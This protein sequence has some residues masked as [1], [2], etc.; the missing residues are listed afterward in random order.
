[1]KGARLAARGKEGKKA[2]RPVG[3]WK[4]GKEEGLRIARLRR[5]LK[6]GSRSV[7]DKR[8]V[9]EHGGYGKGGGGA[10]ADDGKR[11][12]GFSLAQARVVVQEGPFW[13]NVCLVTFFFGA[14]RAPLQI[15][16]VFYVC[17]GL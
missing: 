1:M 10:G 11:V 16:I 8:S 9:A 15:S 2:R 12:E 5:G 6:L 17:L 4:E 13:D 3:K 14:T 7:S